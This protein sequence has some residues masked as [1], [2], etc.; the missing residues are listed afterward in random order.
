MRVVFAGT[1]EPAVI[2]LEAI[3]ASRHELVGVVARPDAPAGRGRKLVASPVAQYAEELGGIEILKPVKPSDPEFLARLREIAPDACPVVAYGGL[4][5]QAALDIPRYGWINLHFS[6]LPAWRG[7]APVQHSIIAGDDVTGASTFRIVKALDAGAV[8]HV[9]RSFM[10]SLE[11]GEAEALPP[12]LRSAPPK[13]GEDVSY[14]AVV[15]TRAWLD[16]GAGSG[17][18][19][20]ILGRVSLVFADASRRL[21]QIGRKREAEWWP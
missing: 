11:P 8:L 5:P 12:E 10:T 1:P 13:T 4:L 21:A 6:V 2:A 15:L 20:L 18:G 14:W 19:V 3:V 17:N 9:V 16:S 7:A